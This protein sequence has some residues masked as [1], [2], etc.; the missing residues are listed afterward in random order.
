MDAQNLVAEATFQSSGTAGELLSQLSDQL[1][2][3]ATADAMVVSRQKSLNRLGRIAFGGLPV[4]AGVAA[5]SLGDASTAAIAVP[6]ALVVG[7][8][9]ALYLGSKARAITRPIQA[10]GGR[11]NFCRFMLESLVRDATRDGRFEVK[12]KLQEELSLL[13]EG[14]NPKRA[15]AWQS[16]SHDPWWSV[17]GRLSDGTLVEQTLTALERRRPKGRLTKMRTSC[18][19]HLRLVY[20]PAVY[21][22][23][24]FTTGKVKN[25]F[26]LLDHATVKAALAT[27]K[28]VSVKIVV[29]KDTGPRRLHAASEAALLGGYRM[30][31]LA[32]LKAPSSAKGAG[33]AK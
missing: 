32:R 2:R 4:L 20:D 9:V 22:D 19:I 26:R 31:N 8:A 12:L 13:S 6:V 17:T 5:F 10:D 33:G 3:I 28:H 7:I 18:L 1:S 29:T 30:L 16:L 21:G 25:P 27:N 14:P 24:S 15:G 23:A 11:V